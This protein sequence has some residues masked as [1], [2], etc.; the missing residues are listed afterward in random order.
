MED[1]KEHIEAGLLFGHEGSTGRVSSDSRNS[2]PERAHLSHSV[3]P[4]SF[5]VVAFERFIAV[6]SCQRFGFR[7]HR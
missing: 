2:H 6:F 7:C 1:K 5:F 4:P 3:Q